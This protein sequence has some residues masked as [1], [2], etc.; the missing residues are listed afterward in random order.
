MPDIYTLITLK[1]NFK[2]ISEI[3]DKYIFTEILDPCENHNLY[4][5]R[6]L[7]PLMVDR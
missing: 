3:I 4:D 7:W 1:N 6:V 2:I 5:S